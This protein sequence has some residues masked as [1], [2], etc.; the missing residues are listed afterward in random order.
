MTND[1]EGRPFPDITPTSVVR[2]KFHVIENGDID[3]DE[4]LNRLMELMYE[5]PEHSFYLFAEKGLPRP[6]CCF[7]SLVE[8]GSERSAGGGGL[9]GHH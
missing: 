9:K 1:P 7:V 3:S 8:T 4:E 2:S 6:G 5:C